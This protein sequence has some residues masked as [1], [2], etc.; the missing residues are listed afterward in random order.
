[1]LARSALRG[2]LNPTT[3]AVVG[4]SNDADKTT[5]RP[6]AFLKRHNFTGEVWPINPNRST[7]QGLRA[8][9]S[10]R[11]L[12]HVPDHAFIVLDAELALL[13]AED[14]VALGVPYVTLL[15]SGFAE[16][17]H[18][19]SERE[20][21]LRRLLAGKST[22]LLGPNSL[23][24]VNCSTGLALTANAAFAK[25][26]LLKG[27]VSVISQSGSAIGTFVSRGRARNIGFAN[28]IS[29]GNE[30]DLSVGEI[31]RDILDDPNTDCVLLFLESIK[32]VAHLEA[33][34]EHAA[35]VKKPV[36]AYKLGRSAVGAQLAVS[37][38]GA[39]VTSDRAVDALFHDLGIRRLDIF[40]ALLEAPPLFARASPN[41]VDRRP[42]VAVIATTGGGGALVVDRLGLRGVDVAGPTLTVSERLAAAGAHLGA[43][44]LIDVTLAGTRPPVMRAAIDAALDENTYDA[45]VVAI[46][47]SAET[48]PEL[49]VQPI[50]DAIAARGQSTKPIAVFVVPHSD[51]ALA[52]FA[53]ARIAAFRTPEACADAVALRLART[54]APRRPAHPPNVIDRRV[55]EG[56]AGGSEQLSEVVALDLFDAI[57][58]STARRISIPMAELASAMARA[59]DLR[60]PL[61]VKL[62]SADL[63]HKTEAGAVV[64]GVDA[65]EGV[66]P[67]IDRML[68]SARLHAPQARLDGI[69]LQEQ[70]GG[71]QEV[72]IGLTREPAIGPFVT[73][74][75]GGIFAELYQDFA[76]WRAPVS[77][78]EAQMMIGEVRGLR[79]SDGYRGGPRGDLEALARAVAAFSSLAACDWIAEVE[80]NP[81]IIGHAGEGA[82]AVD[83]LV[84]REGAGRWK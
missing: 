34:A 46:G 53:A 15:A 77:V 62:V 61:V 2:L 30:V 84:R 28:L 59:R 42:R 31:G 56:I 43:G 54:R 52:L 40:E 37:H 44:T 17:G 11:D 14:A 74:G 49:A 79:I 27:S 55:F 18:D 71:V 39:M 20:D 70:L 57:G 45:I 4:A 8:Y 82:H 81:L 41:I 10:L 64:L 24:L 50:V 25:A 78:A 66:G 6:I 47:S 73:L 9:T 16:S 23:G 22:R 67:A 68:S 76:V 75:V 38:T 21:R 3:V 29:V 36:L 83:G 26:P 35:R 33:F 80:I 65:P 1:M 5:G 32:H 60:P 19:G 69:L 58:I 13:A 63:P 7:V 72:I 12:P 51:N 48:Y